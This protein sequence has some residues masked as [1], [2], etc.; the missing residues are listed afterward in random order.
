MTIKNSLNIITAKHLCERVHA[1]HKI[2]FPQEIET[3]KV[4]TVIFDHIK[5]DLHNK[6]ELSLHKY[7][8][9]KATQH[10]NFCCAFRG[11]TSEKWVKI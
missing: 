6:I 2:S 11:M 3:T 7:D 5:I 8:V 9:V 10:N 4:N 1:F